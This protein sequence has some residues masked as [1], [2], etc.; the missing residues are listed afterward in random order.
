MVAEVGVGVEGDDGVGVEA[1]DGEMVGVRTGMDTDVDDEAAVVDRRDDVVARD[2]VDSVD[3]ERARYAELLVALPF[4]RFVV[5]IIGGLAC[6][7]SSYRRATRFDEREG[8][9]VGDGNG[10]GRDDAADMTD[11]DEGDVK[12][13]ADILG[14]SLDGLLLLAVVLP[15]PTL[16]NRCSAIVFLCDRRR[17]QCSVVMRSVLCMLLYQV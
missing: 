14:V 6:T 8:D 17:M 7:V 5:T 16:L 9:D 11:V 15:P 3:R 1:E 13:V 12:D 2:R 4:V 10:E